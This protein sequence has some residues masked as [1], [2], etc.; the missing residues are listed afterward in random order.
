MDLKFYLW[1]HE[2]EPVLIFDKVFLF[3]IKPNRII[4]LL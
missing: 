1:K 3:Y 4:C 2:F